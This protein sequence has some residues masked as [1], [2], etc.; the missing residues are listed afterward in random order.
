MKKIAERIERLFTDITFAEEGVTKQPKVV[1]GGL[2]EKLDKLFTAIT[3]A[4][5]D[6]FETART[7]MSDGS[8]GH[9]HLTEYCVPGFCT[10]NA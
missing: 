2:A 6:E 7:I 4:E 8:G 5:G 3:F 1:I 10:I 9:G